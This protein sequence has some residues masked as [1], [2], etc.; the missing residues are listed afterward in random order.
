MAEQEATLIGYTTVSTIC[1]M[2]LYRRKKT[3]V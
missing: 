2:K 1:D 3:I